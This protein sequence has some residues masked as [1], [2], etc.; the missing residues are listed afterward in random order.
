MANLATLL[1][2]AVESGAERPAVKL[3]D[4]V[5]NYGALDAGAARAAG[6]LKERGVGAGDR[7]GLQLPNLPYFPI[8]FFGILRLGATVVPLNP[9][10]KDREV[11]FQLSDSEA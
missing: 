1:T 6:I 3:D 11:G 7:V 4:N 9:L 8:V 2:E 10:L 5:L